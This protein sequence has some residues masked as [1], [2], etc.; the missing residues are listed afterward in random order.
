[1]MQVLDVNSFRLINCLG[2]AP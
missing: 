1:M 2:F